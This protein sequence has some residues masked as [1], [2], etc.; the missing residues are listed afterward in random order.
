MHREIKLF[1]H[2]KCLLQYRYVGKLKIT[3]TVSFAK[4]PCNIFK[5]CWNLMCLQED[6]NHHVA[7][8]YFRTQLLF[9]YYY[10]TINARS[11]KLRL[12]I[13]DIGV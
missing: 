13:I 10:P 7:V 4:V 8:I 5:A 2:N 9:N 3:I 12:Q 6:L 11:T 1:R